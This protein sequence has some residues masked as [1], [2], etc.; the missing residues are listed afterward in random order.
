MGL[1]RRKGDNRPVDDEALAAELA[2]LDAVLAR[3]PRGHVLPF[4]TP[5]RCPACGD[6]GFVTSVNQGAGA[7]YN[8]C[9]TC[10]HDW[11]IT[12]RAIKAHGASLRSSQQ[13]NLGPGLGFGVGLGGEAASTTPA[14]D[15][16]AEAAASLAALGL[17]R[18]DL[19]VPIDRP[20][21]LLVV[22]DNPSDVALLESILRPVTPDGV[23]VVAVPTR[24]E[25][26][27][28]ARLGFDVVLL[29]LGLPDSQGLDTL[30]SFGQACP[31]PPLCV[32]TGDEVGA[33]WRGLAQSLLL[34]RDLP[35]LV[36]DPRTGGRELLQLLRR[37]I[38]TPLPTA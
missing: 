23:Q 28:A 6:F 12:V 7:A 25:G 29:D 14:T 22:E 16:A 1:F 36:G 37:T 24:H 35:R 26:E 5:C 21:Q 10:H 13:A 38:V 3:Y 34:K 11:V 19:P 32:C 8:S 2:V 33:A 18:P 31:E 20:L 4:G 15:P 17:A 9:L 27:N 30:R